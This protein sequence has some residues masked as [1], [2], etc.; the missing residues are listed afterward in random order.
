MVH[1]LLKTIWQF[2][3]KG[4]ITLLYDL[5]ILLLAICSKEMKTYIPQ[6]PYMPISMAVL[7]SRAPN[8]KHP[9]VHQLVNG[10]WYIYTMI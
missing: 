7:F 5:A 10:R 2:F 3:K 6:N 9:N 8:W 1:L 4:N